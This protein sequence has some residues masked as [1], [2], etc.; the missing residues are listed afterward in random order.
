MQA[1]DYKVNKSE[2]LRYMGYSGQGIDDELNSRIE[3]VAAKCE[4]TIEPKY[5]YNVYEIKETDEGIELLGTGV[6]FLGQD[7]ANHMKG[8][9]HCAVMAATIGMGVE[10]ELMRMEYKSVSDALIFNAACTCLIEQVADR[11]E[12]EII[13]LAKS[14]DMTT[15]YRYSPGYGDF[16]LGQQPDVLRLV[17]ADTRIGINLT[18]S[19]LMIPRKSVSAVIPMFP[20]GVRQKRSTRTCANCNNY[21]TCEFRKGGVS[22]GA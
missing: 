12:A 11:C 6:T 3:A 4:R 7:I 21:E 20:K 14:R 10:R 19:M 13:K 2:H 5:C 9:T 18:E 17:C 15:D 1:I 16:P 8:A 22:C